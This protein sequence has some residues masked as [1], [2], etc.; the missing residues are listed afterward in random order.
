ML[1]IK[2]VAKIKWLLICY[3]VQLNPW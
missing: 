3:N 1:H 2:D